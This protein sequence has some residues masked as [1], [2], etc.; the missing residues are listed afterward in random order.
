MED[1]GSTLASVMNGL[2][3]GGSGDDYPD[4]LPESSGIIMPQTKTLAV[5]LL[6][7]AI[8]IAV[9]SYFVR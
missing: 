2:G 3:A 7:T 9:G 6:V 1:P 4:E 8:L 5:I